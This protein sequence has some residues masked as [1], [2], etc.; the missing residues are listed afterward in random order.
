MPYRRCSPVN[1]TQDMACNYQKAWLRHVRN[2]ILLH[3]LCLFWFLNIRNFFQLF[4]TSRS[5]N[6]K[7]CITFLI[8][9]HKTEELCNLSKMCLSQAPSVF[10]NVRKKKNQNG[11][12]AKTQVQTK[13]KNYYGSRALKQKKKACELKY[14]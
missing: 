9:F 7:I 8:T 3:L 11:V 13:C 2:N 1:V 5:F 14:E 6:I 10:Q 4:S 12:H